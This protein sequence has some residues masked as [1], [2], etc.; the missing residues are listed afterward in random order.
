MT[1]PLLTDRIA[2]GCAGCMGRREFLSQSALLAA[3]AALAACGMDTVTSPS[4]NG[5]VDVTVSDYAAL[6]NVGGIA[7]VTAGGAALAVVR[8]G[9]SSFVALSRV[10][11][12]QGAIVNV[13]GNGFL[14][15]GHGA[16][17][18]STG[19]WTG[20]QRTSSLHAYTTSYN[21]TSGMLTISN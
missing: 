9:A 6:A 12:H 13:S 7:L 5:S 17:F 15:P 10:C 19:A 14:C 1:G 8:T 11:P 2:G 20:G 18:T 16:Q 21:A 3:A 4:L